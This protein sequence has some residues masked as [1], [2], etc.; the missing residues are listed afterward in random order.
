MLP[1][2]MIRKVDISPISDGLSLD[3]LARWCRLE[4]TSF[5]EYA[6]LTGNEAFLKKHVFPLYRE[7]ADFYEDYLTMDG[8]SLYHICPSVSPENAPPGTDT[9]LSKDATMDVAIAKEVFRL[10]S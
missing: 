2:I 5:Y 6:M 3:V 4:Y 8:D 1:I 9:W 7:M 10:L